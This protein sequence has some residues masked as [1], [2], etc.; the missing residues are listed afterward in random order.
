MLLN[1]KGYFHL[2]IDNL[3]AV[4]GHNCDDALEVVNCGTVYGRQLLNHEKRAYTFEVNQRHERA[5]K[6]FGPRPLR[7]YHSDHQGF[8]AQSVL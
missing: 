6:A 8:I 3:L 1:V 7:A 2:G 5:L 4:Q